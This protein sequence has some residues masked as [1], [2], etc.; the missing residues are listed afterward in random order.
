MPDGNASWFY[1]ANGQ[2]AGPVSADALRQLAASGQLRATDMVWS[3]GMANWTPVGQVPGLLPAE[4]SARIPPPLPAQP[5][6]YH[7]P[8]PSHVGASDPGMRWL[9][10]VDRSGWAI[11]AGYLG[12]FSVL[13]LPAPIA[14]AISI[15]AI[16]DIR[17][18]PGRHGMGRAVFGLIFGGL[19]S[20]G[21]VLMVIA[22]VAK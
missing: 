22:L 17:K 5:L 9:L 10:P 18:H 1:A 21:F 20:I 13:V 8:P 3:E 7:V 15:I 16:R 19:F 12:L 14:L 4:V 11:A 6:P 2:Q